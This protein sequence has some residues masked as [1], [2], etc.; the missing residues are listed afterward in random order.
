MG[1]IIE[2]KKI[3]AYFCILFIVFYISLLI[4]LYHFILQELC[5]QDESLNKK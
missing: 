2:F 5:E 3:V 1:R 4:V